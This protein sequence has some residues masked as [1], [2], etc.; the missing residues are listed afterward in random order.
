MVQW[1]NVSWE[2]ACQVLNEIDFRNVCS[3]WMAPIRETRKQFLFQNI[4]TSKN[5]NLELLRIGYLFEKSCYKKNGFEN[6]D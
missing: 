6:E 1:A 4:L 2:E 5:S 3:Y